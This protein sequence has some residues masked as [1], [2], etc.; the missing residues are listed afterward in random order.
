MASW[1]FLNSVSTERSF[2]SAHVGQKSSKKRTLGTAQSYQVLVRPCVGSNLHALRVSVLETINAGTVVDAL[3]PVLTIYKG[4]SAKDEGG[5]YNAL[6]D[7]KGCF[8]II[9]L[10]FINDVPPFD[11]E[12]CEHQIIVTTSP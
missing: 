11:T 6:T 12:G 2:G 3:S 4:V 10:E 5:E 1:V 7:E 9:F 8:A